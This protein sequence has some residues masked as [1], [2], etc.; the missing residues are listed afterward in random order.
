MEN[1]TEII[2][3]NKYIASSGICTRKEA[4]DLIKKGLIT[5]NESICYEPFYEV[6]NNDV[7]SYKGLSLIHISEP[8]RPY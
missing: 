2:R 6:K 4:V 7:V 5:I 8:T 3:L 1:K